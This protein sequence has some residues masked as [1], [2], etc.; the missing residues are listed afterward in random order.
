MENKKPEE[1]DLSIIVCCHKQDY[2]HKGAGFLPLQVG[3]ANA[4]VDLGIQGDDTGDSISS[5]N[6]NFCELTGHYWL[7]K[8]G[9][10]S[11]YIGLNHYRRYFDFSHKLPY[12]TNIFETTPQDIEK[13]FP[14]LPDLD[15]IFSKYDVIVAKPHIHS[16]CG[17]MHYRQYRIPND[18]DILEGVIKEKFPEYWPS[19][20]KI[21]YQNNKFSSCNMFIMKYDTFQDYSKWLFDLLF[22]VER[23]VHISQYSDQARIFGY[24]SEYLLNVYIYHNRLKA[25]KVPIAMVKDRLDN[26]NNIRTYIKN[27]L[28]AIRYNLVHRLLFPRKSHYNPNI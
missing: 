3:K 26:E 16:F 1:N 21:M 11:K 17:A 6:P 19:Y 5:K 27:F 20:Y 15:K 28:I 10:H 2:Y 23:R 25:M 12:G 7:W 14:T 24:M 18:L 9:P 22:E 13:N 4:K 8:N